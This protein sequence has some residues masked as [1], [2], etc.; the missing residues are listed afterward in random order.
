MIPG[1]LITRQI[2]G[3]LVNNFEKLPEAIGGGLWYEPNALIKD[4]KRFGPVRLQ[5]K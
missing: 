2:Q 5:E 3:Y 1:K 4:A